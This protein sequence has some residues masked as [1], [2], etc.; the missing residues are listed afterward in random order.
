MNRYQRTAA[1]AVLVIVFGAAGLGKLVAG[2]SFRDQFLQFGLPEWWVHVTGAVELLGAALVALF[3]KTPRQ[4]GAALLAVTMAV[5]TTL[6]LVHDPV[7]LVLPALALMLLA[8]Y[9]VLIARSEV[10]TRG[11]AGA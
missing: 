8:G 10:A 11:G 9:V 3:K 6:H 7:P 1:I 5:A 4:V 2:G